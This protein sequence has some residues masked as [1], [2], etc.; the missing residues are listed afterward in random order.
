MCLIHP[1]ERG[2]PCVIFSCRLAQC[3][4]CPPCQS[5]EFAGERSCGDHQPTASQASTAATSLSPIRWLRPILD[6]RHLNCVLLKWLFKMLTL[7]QILSQVHPGDCFFS[8]DLNF[9]MQMA[10]YSSRKTRTRKPTH[11]PAS[12][13]T[14]FPQSRCSLRSST[15]SGRTDAQSS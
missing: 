3:G 10:Q 11:G 15:G 9:H 7:K 4:T 1:T 8:M 12:P 6:L 14:H 13:F 2:F 5:N